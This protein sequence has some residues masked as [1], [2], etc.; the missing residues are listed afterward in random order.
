MGVEKQ[1]IKVILD[2]SGQFLVITII[3]LIVLFVNFG[4]N[5]FDFYDA[6][7]KFLMK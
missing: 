7:I 3:F 5:Q 2:D 6:I 4:D 1:K